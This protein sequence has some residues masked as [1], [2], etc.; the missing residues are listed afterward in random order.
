MSD[1]CVFSPTPCCLLE[2]CLLCIEKNLN[3]TQP[4]AYGSHHGPALSRQWPPQDPNLETTGEQ[5]QEVAITRL[6]TEVESQNSAEPHHIFLVSTL[7]RGYA[8]DQYGG[9]SVLEYNNLSHLLDYTASH[10]QLGR[11]SLGQGLANDSYT[12]GSGTVSGTLRLVDVP[13]DYPATTDPAAQCQTAEGLS[14]CSEWNGQQVGQ[15][16]GFGGGALLRA[17]GSTGLLRG[18]GLL[19]D[20]HSFPPPRDRSHYRPR[21]V[22]YPPT[23]V[24]YP[25]NGV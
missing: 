4:Y 22:G 12:P 11:F 1:K 21:A 24:G 7:H 9:Y 25:R 5:Y 17:E 14:L 8:L 6:A 3:R 13:V 2:Q 10:Q 19:K 23:G 16:R 15:R 20:V 18:R